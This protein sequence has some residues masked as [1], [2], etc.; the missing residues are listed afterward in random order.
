MRKGCSQ[1]GVVGGVEEAPGAF[2]GEFEGAQGVGWSRSLQDKMV[3][4]IQ[5]KISR[6]RKAFSTWSKKEKGPRILAMGLLNPYLLK[7]QLWCSEQGASRKVG[8]GVYGAASKAKM[9]QKAPPPR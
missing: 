2:G 1:S 4:S 8:V 5:A 6:M 3:A 7:G 9:I